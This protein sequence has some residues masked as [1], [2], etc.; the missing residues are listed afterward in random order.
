MTDEIRRLFGYV[1]VSSRQQEERGLSV[2]AQTA[3]LTAWAE[4]QEVHLVRVEVDAAKSGGTL[5]RPALRRVLD[6]LERG[7]ADGIVVVKLDRLTRSLRDLSTLIDRYFGTRFTLAS[8]GESV[9]TG[10]ASGRMVVNL[11]MTVAQWEREITAERNAAVRDYKRQQ[12]EHVG[13]KAP[14]GFSID[15]SGDKPMLVADSGE[16]ETI[17][18]AH[19]LRREGCSQ[20]AIAQVLSDEGRLRRPDNFG[21]RNTQWNRQAVGRLLQ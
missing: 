5:E 8:V 1:R 15:R 12:G 18:R 17:K 10:T 14:F 16:Q 21:N 11:L 9:D 4:A 7:K 6:A 13:G 19:E 20:L 3:R 2:K